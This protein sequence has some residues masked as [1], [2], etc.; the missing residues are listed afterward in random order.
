M[1]DRNPGNRPTIAEILNHPWMMN[2]N[3]E[4]AEATKQRMQQALNMKL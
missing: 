3:D 2:H 4:P 1:F